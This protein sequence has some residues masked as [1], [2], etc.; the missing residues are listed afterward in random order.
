[1]A[2]LLLGAME[3]GTGS[4][5]YGMS[6]VAIHRT[7]NCVRGRIFSARGWNSQEISREIMEILVSIIKGEIKVNKHNSIIE[8]V[9]VYYS[10]RYDAEKQKLI[11]NKL[12]IVYP[13]K[14]GILYLDPQEGRL[15]TAHR[16]QTLEQIIN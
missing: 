14:D 5:I 7:F 4:E 13:V 3:G 8:S 2:G 12:G 1:M 9:V 11:C 10:F 6:I 15:T 16:H